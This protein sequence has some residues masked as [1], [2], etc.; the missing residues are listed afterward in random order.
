MDQLCS[1]PQLRIVALF[2]S[3]ERNGYGSLEDSESISIDV[4]NTN[5][6]ITIGTGSF[7][8]IV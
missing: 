2:H 3:V 5:V 1:N 6:L 8:G 7:G 4:D